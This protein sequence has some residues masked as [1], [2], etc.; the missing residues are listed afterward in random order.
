MGLI[1]SLNSVRRSQHNCEA[2]RETGLAVKYRSV[3]SVRAINLTGK[4]VVVTGERGGSAR[5][6]SVVLQTESRSAT[7]MFSYGTFKWSI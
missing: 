5:S 1:S 3:T 7:C 4:S 6:P 2:P